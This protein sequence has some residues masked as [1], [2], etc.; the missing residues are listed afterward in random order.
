M[1]NN[2]YDVRNKFYSRKSIRNYLN[3]KLSQEMINIL[4]DI[5]FSGPVSGGLKCVFIKEI[6]NIEEKHICYKGTYYQKHVLEAPHIF[7]IGCDDSIIESK[8]SGEYVSTFSCQNSVV[9]AQNII[10]AAHEIELGTCFIGSIRKNIIIKYLK[11]EKG[12]NP[13]CI[14][15]LG[16]GDN[17][18][19]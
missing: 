18:G 13:W 16:V 10:M 14:L 5:G 19:I 9:A 1:W 8:Y 2:L 11:L 4:I 12:Y 17:V 7:L 15:C 6:N 3:F